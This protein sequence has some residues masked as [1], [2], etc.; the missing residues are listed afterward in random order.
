MNRIP[1]VQ[2]CKYG[3]NIFSFPCELPSAS[4]TI[5]IDNLKEARAKVQ[6]HQFPESE[7]NAKTN[8]EMIKKLKK[9]RTTNRMVS[10]QNYLF[11]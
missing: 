3:H 2:N 9:K 6:I 5:M 1:A 7:Q 8:Y 4:N 11:V 10:V